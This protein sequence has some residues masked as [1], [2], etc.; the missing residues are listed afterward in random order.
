M[1]NPAQVEAAVKQHGTIF[2][3][4]NLN[5]VA[6]QEGQWFCEYHL[7]IPEEGDDYIIDGSLVEYL[8]PCDSYVLDSAGKPAPYGKP[9]ERHRVRPECSESDRRPHGEILI[10]QS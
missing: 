3:D 1:L 2:F 4:A 6:P 5:P 7:E 10:L 9:A 8:G